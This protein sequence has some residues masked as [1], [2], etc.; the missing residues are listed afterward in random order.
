MEFKGRYIRKKLQQFYF[1]YRPGFVLK[2]ACRTN[3][4]TVLPLETLQLL[5]KRKRLNW[6][7]FTTRKDIRLLIIALRQQVQIFIA[8]SI[9]DTNCIYL[10]NDFV[11]PFCS[12]VSRIINQDL[13]LVHRGVL[14]ES[15]L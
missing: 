12:Q 3:R 15:L 2:V 6:W 9:S 14:M 10:S 1:Y 4:S 11:S 13:A 7:F 5:E 8:R